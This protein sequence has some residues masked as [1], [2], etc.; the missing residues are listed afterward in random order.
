MSFCTVLVVE[1]LRIL[2]V[3][4][5]T[6]GVQAITSHAMEC[7]GGAN[8]LQVRNSRTTGTSSRGGTAIKQAVAQRGGGSTFNLS[9]CIDNEDRNDSQGERLSK[10]IGRLEI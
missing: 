3:R 1:I 6:I 8:T 4:C 5:R 2:I 7:R 9:L 10:H